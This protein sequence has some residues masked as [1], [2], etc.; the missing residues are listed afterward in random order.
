[1]TLEQFNLVVQQQCQGIPNLEKIIN[2]KCKF[3]GDHVEVP[4][5]RRAQ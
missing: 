4:I 3:I 5:F 1:M 2:K